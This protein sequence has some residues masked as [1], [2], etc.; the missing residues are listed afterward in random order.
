[1]QARLHV[2]RK[3]TRGGGEVYVRGFVH[4][5]RKRQLR[6][7]IGEADIEWYNGLWGGD[8]EVLHSAIDD[9]EPEAAHIISIALNKVLQDGMKTTHQEIWHATEALC[10]PDPRDGP[11]GTREG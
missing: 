5:G 1:M 11:L 7:R 3:T 2:L 9:E 10:K 4:F 8:Y 6:Y